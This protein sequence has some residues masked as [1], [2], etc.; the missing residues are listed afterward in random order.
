[1]VSLFAAGTWAIAHGRFSGEKMVSF[2][3]SLVLLIEP[4]QAVGS[5]YNE[6]KQGQPAVERVF[7]VLDTP[8][9]VSLKVGNHYWFCK[10]D[11]CVG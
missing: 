9:E 4:I 5:A 8:S 3:T 10:R 11:F 6:I 1:V 7:E 2:I